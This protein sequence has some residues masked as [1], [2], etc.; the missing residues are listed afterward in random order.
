MEAEK[1]AIN[2]S[3]SSLWKIF[4]NRFWILLIVGVVCFAGLFAYSKL[5]FV[6][7]YESTGKMY[8]LRQRQS[9]EYQQNYDYQSSLLITAD[10]TEILKTRAVL[11]QVIQELPD[12]DG[13]YTYN[14]LK[15]R[16]SVSNPT[17]TRIL[18][19]S[20]RADTQKDARLITDKLG[21]VGARKIT[22]LL[23]DDQ[24]DYFEKGYVPSTPCNTPSVVTMALISFAAMVLI[25]GVFVLIFI[26]NEHIGTS[27]EIEKRLHVAMLGE[28]PDA[29]KTQRRGGPM[30]YLRRYG[31]YGKYSQYSY[32]YGYGYGAKDAKKSKKKQKTDKEGK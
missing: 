27:E 14:D 13:K 2:I 28:I 5:T 32:M 7:Q 20:V 19:I 10:C 24:A 8:I 15:S 30:R 23:G 1:N 16:I 6:P 17:E 25:Y 29:S 4:I 26:K 11:E 12:L 3:L 9:D 22:E 21:E 31:K 18:E